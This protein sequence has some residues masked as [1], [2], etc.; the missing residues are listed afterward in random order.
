M[1]SAG[2]Q[3]TEREGSMESGEERRRERESLSHVE[4]EVAARLLHV[5]FI[6]YSLLTFHAMQLFFS[7]Q[8]L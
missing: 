4:V 6:L 7:Y 8:T 5:G 2:E 1:V 3:E